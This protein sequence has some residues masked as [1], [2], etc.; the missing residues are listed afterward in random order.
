MPDE[1]GGGGAAA[2]ALGADGVATLGAGAAGGAAVAA[3]GDEGKAID[4]DDGAA[5]ELNP[6]P[7]DVPVDESPGPDDD[8]PEPVDEPEE[9]DEPDELEESKPAAGV[10]SAAV[11]PLASTLAPENVSWKP[12]SAS[13][14]TGLATGTIMIPD[15]PPGVMSDDTSP[16][17]VD[18]AASSCRSTLRP[19]SLGGWSPQ[20]P[21]L[22]AF[23]AELTMAQAWMVGADGPATDCD[24]V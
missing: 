4:G 21:G 24:W 11:V 10:E 12:G 6:E 20:A 14:P 9:P 1:M 7:D 13:P 18:E 19:Q 22:S 17:Q 16:F 2:G 3:A 23:H 15:G 5:V 8:E